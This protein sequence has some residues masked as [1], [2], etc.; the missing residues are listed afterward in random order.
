MITENLELM[1]TAPR[2]KGRPE[3]LGVRNVLAFL[4]NRLTEDF[5]KVNHKV[6]AC[7]LQATFPGKKRMTTDTIRNLLKY[8]RNK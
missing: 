3:D 4:D 1:A 5:G 2:D 7:F 8:I 6:A